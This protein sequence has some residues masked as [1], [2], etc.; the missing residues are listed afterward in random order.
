MPPLESVPISDDPAT[1]DLSPWW[2]VLRCG[3]DEGPRH[4]S[5]EYAVIQAPTSQRAAGRLAQQLG[6]ALSA[7]VR[8][9][10]D[11]SEL[12]IASVCGETSQEVFLAR[13]DVTLLAEEGA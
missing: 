13:P 11:S 12:A 4:P 5:C 8:G 2:L 7:Y 3:T 10:F 1:E 9:P 6:G